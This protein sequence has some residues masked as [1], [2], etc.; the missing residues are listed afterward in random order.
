MSKVICEK[1]KTCTSNCEHKILHRLKDSC[2]KPCAAHGNTKCKLVEYK[3]END[4]DWL[5]TK[6]N[7]GTE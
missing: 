2:F 7:K 1:Y 6:T 4:L 5:S 3:K